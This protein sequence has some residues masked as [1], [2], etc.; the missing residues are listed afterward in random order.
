MSLYSGKLESQPKT[1]AQAASS[2]PVPTLPPRL[3]HWAGTS[4]LQSEK[5]AESRLL[6]TE[7]TATSHMLRKGAEIKVFDF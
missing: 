5:T 2:S 7:V 4:S 3:Q 1:R 6:L